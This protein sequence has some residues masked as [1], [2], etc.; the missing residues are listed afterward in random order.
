MKASHSYVL[1]FIVK[2]VGKRNVSNLIFSLSFSFGLSNTSF[3]ST[4]APFGGAT[5]S[6]FGAPAVATPQKN[7]ARSADDTEEDSTD[8]EAQ[9]ETRQAVASNLFS[10]PAA[11]TFAAPSFSTTTPASTVATPPAFNSVFGSSNGSALTSG[12]A[13]GQSSA[14]GRSYGG[15]GV[16]TPPQPQAA[17][18]TPPVNASNSG[19]FASFANETKVG[20]GALGSKDNNFSSFG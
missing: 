2:S 3:A 20:F 11:P 15:F 17:A 10:S 18:T 7:D 1:C 8:D 12:V 16:S 4:S 5:L 13:F 9:V 6:G 14:L 19:G